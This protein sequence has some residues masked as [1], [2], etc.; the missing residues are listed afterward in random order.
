MK[1]KVI[2]LS[3]LIFIVLKAETHYVPEDFPSIQN[4]IDASTN[5]DTIIVSTGVYFENINFNGKSIT[6]TSR[7][8]IDNDPLIVGSTLIDAQGIASGVTFSSGEGQ[9]SVIAGFTIQNGIGNNE[10]PDGNGSF[11]TYGGGIYC[12]DSSPLIKDCIIKDNI[13]NQGGGAGIFCY[14]AS[15]VFEGCYIFDNE[16]DDVGGGFYARTGS[17][18]E[19]YDCTF[20]NNTAEFGGGCYIRNESSPIL[21]NV[22]FNQNT[23]NNSGGAIAIKDDVNLSAIQV[24]IVDNEAEGLGGGLYVN[25]ASPELSF[26]LIADNFS[27]AGGGAYI[28]DPSTVVMTNTTVAN[29][30]AGSY[31]NAVYMRDG[32]TLNLLNTI[33]WGNGTS[34]IY[35]RPEGQDL[36]LNSSYSI[37]ENGQ[38]G[39]EVNNNGDLNWGNG[40]LT[41]DPFFCP[42]GNYYVR[43]N[44]PVLNSG[45]NGSLIGC[46]QS[47]CGPLNMGPIWYVDINGDNQNDGSLEAPFGTISRAMTSAQNGDTIRVTSGVYTEI[48][49]FVNKQVVLESMAFYLD[50]SSLI[51]ETFFAPGPLGGSCLTLSGPSNNSGTIKGITFRGGSDPYGGGISIINC[52]P[53][54]SDLIIEDNTA[55]IGGGLYLSG[56]EAILNNIII[57]GNGAN[58]GGGVY[59]TEG[60]PTFENVT[61]KDNIA[62][63][64][65]G[66]YFENSQAIIDHGVIRL[67]NALIEGAGIYQS[68]GQSTIE[69]VSFEDNNGYDYGGGFVANQATVYMDQITFS[70]NSAVVGSI[71]AMYNSAIDIDNSILWG[72]SGSH[73]YAP[74]SQ[75]GASYLGISFSNIQG[76]EESI[77]PEQNITFNTSGGIIDED[78]LF[79]MTDGSY[80]A[81]DEA[82]VCLTASNSSGLIGAYDEIGCSSLRLDKINAYEM[83]LLYNYPNPF[84]PNTN[85]EFKL[86][87]YSQFS[88]D[89]FDIT[90][91]LVRNLDGGYGSPG[92]YAA[93]WDSRNDLGE[94]VPSGVY[95]YTLLTDDHSI[96]KRMVLMK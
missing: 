65:G 12:E 22:I 74:E 16:T 41:D 78:P 9:E 85:I 64:G 68:G 57:R 18:P 52:S 28:R 20:L 73:F 40:N 67:N 83:N 19:F 90:G 15:P 48:I 66:F 47:D 36:E 23:A 77:S 50:D 80:Y 61:V 8:I 58:I 79:C 39:I 35:F 37:I 94:K 33:V 14:N 10:D 43:E 59:A 54:L 91:R 25:D 17:S 69:W 42:Q 60:S 26:C 38:A 62:Y 30:S 81:L 2:I 72:N 63:W 56:S 53:T 1:A 44:S 34:Q 31:G 4:A 92:Q 21:S 46:F 24:V 86:E 93:V 70:G 13:A 95:F 87:D 6:V 32:A 7:Y 45:L 27:G 3:C 71:V 82:S 96:T 29:N 51:E 89:I 76:G 75:D 55:D 49:D 11:Y 88:L 5:G 84:N